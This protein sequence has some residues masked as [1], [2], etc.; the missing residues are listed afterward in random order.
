MLGLTLRVSQVLLGCLALG[1][2]SAVSQLKA[3]EPTYD[4]RSAVVTSAPGIAPPGLLSATG[5]R[6]NAAIAA[7]TR[8]T[9]LPKVALIIRLAEVRKGQGFSE[10]RNVAKVTIDATSVSTG[11][12]I[13]I[14]SF[15][16]TTF[17][18]DP[19]VADDLMAEDIAARVRSTF[20]LKTPHLG[21]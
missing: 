3:P 15:E 18:T 20:A 17:V 8:N 1:A 7:T 21:T 19:A 13:A 12:V 10:E 9:P 5:D 14:A 6:V 11:S 2:C 16:T 4:V